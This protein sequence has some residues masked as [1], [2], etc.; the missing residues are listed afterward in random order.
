VRYTYRNIGRVLEDVANAPVAAYDLEVPGLS[1]VEYILTNPSSKTPV[2]ATAAFLGA[3][4]DDPVHKYHAVEVMLNRRFS[5]NWSALASYRWSRLRG[6][7]EGFYRDDNGQSDP[8][9][10]SLYDFPTNDPSYTAIGVPQFGYQGDIRYLGDPNGILPLDR[11]H[12]I[13]FSGSY[14]FPMGVGLGLGMNLSSGAPLTPLAAHP[15]YSNGGEI[16][17]GPRGS[18]IQTIDGFKTRTPFQKNVDLQASYNIRLGG[19]NARKLTVL[20]DVFNVFNWQTVQMYD[21]WTQLTGPAPNPDFGAPVTQ[22]LFG[23]PP[24]FQIPR[25]I[26]FGARFSF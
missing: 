13:K 14:A 8:G 6:N 16:P 2:L 15:S 24:Q 20:A 26:R 17:L 25:Q 1:S 3:A 22:V 18:G 10:T 19:T 5:G 11:P 9:I 21:Q 12:Q 7:F 4:F 23:A